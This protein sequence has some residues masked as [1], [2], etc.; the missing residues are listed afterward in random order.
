MEVIANNCKKLRRLRVE[1]GDREVQ[2]GFVTQ[3]GL[4]AIALSCHHLEYIAAYVSDIDN[5]ALV[6]IAS[7]CPNLRDFRLVLLDEGNDISDFPLDDGV[8]ALMQKCK[9]MHRFAL[10]L[11]PGCVTDRGMNEMGLYGKSLRWVLFGLLGETDMGLSLFAD[12]CQSLEKLEIRD[13]VYSEAAIASAVLKMRSLKYVW[14]QGYKSS[15]SGQ[16]LLP[17]CNACWRVEYIPATKSIDGMEQPVQFVAY[18]SLSE[19]CRVDHPPS[20]ILLNESIV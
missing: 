17:L 7:N 4:T 12:Y 20:V 11:R 19:R 6:T 5:A 18:R 8:R 9:C 3:K 14:V 1:R 13:C 2:Q 15:G 10:Y 16:D